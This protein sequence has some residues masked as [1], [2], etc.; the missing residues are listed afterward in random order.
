MRYPLKVLVLPRRSDG[1]ATLCM[2]TTRHSSRIA[3]NSLV[4]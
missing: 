4:V 3:Y 1:Q 2:I